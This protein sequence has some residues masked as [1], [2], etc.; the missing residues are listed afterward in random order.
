MNSGQ[1]MKG[2]G[3]PCP[4]RRFIAVLAGQKPSRAK[5]DVGKPLL[6]CLLPSIVKHALYIEPVCC[7]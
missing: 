7:G 2:P 4:V 3:G 6:L 5:Y 1:N